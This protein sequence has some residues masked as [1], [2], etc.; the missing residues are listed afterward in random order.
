MR[1]LT[2]C[3]DYYSAKKEEL[4]QNPRVKEALTYFFQQYLPSKQPTLS[5]GQDRLSKV[6]TQEYTPTDVNQAFMLLNHIVF[7]IK[8]EALHKSLNYQLVIP[9]ESAVSATTKL[10]QWFLELVSSTNKRIVN[11]AD[12]HYHDPEAKIVAL[13]KQLTEC[14]HNLNAL[15]T[16]DEL[17]KCKQDTLETF[18]ATILQF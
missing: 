14:A 9:E 5:Q 13:N 17:V 12:K 2:S 15:P 8:D 10:Q 1:P 11:W 18:T 6:A 3:A 16:I 7:N 4:C